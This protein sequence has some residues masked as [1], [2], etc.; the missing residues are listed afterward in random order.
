MC[1]EERRSE[2]ICT[3]VCVCVLAGVCDGRSEVVCPYACID[4]C[5]THNEVTSIH[6]HAC[7][8]LYS[9]FSL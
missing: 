5:I 9:A 4:T 3:C 8:V 2:V 1:S 7:I 6:V